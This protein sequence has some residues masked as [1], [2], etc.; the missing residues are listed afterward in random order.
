MKL[1][2]GYIKISAVGGGLSAETRLKHISVIDKFH[3]FSIVAQALEMDKDELEVAV[4]IMP[5]IQKMATKIEFDPRV[6][7]GAM[8]KALM[9]MMLMMRTMA[10]NAQHIPAH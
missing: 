5:M 1:M 8:W 3:I 6:F 2:D 10:D 4:A 9:L 7:G